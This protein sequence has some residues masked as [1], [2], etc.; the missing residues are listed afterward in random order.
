[1]RASAFL[2]KGFAI[3]M[4]ELMVVMLSAILVRGSNAQNTSRSNVD[5]TLRGIPA[6]EVVSIRPVKS[7][8]MI[9]TRILEDGISFDGVSTQM[10][11]LRAFGVEAD[12]VINVPNWTKS[13]AYDIEGRISDADI[14]SWEKL[15]RVQKSV[16]LLPLLM[17]RFHLRFHREN[18]DLPVYDLVVARSDRKVNE[19]KLREAK[20]GDTYPNGLKGPDGPIG[21]PD[22]SWIEPGKITGQGIPIAELIRLLSYVEPG[23]TIF[24]KTGLTG[25]YDFVLRWT[26]SDTSPISVNGIEGRKPENDNVLETSGASLFT[27]LQEQLGLKLEL[28]R[29]PVD[30]IIIDHI[31]PPSKN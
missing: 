21:R 5:N 26:P 28:K 20:L 8:S 31:E 1:M 9:S 18:R 7:G 15:T 22:T 14:P 11:L 10:L 25:K 29:G 16:A 24:D 2:N 6:F 13:D 4:A 19:P 23:R 30:A 12:R 27:A 3:V 17:D